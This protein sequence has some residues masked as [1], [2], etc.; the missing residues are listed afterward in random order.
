MGKFYIGSTD[1]VD[2]RVREHNEAELGAKTFTHKLGPWVLLWSERHVSRA[3][4][5]AR[6]KQ[7]KRMK[8][9]K[10]GRDMRGKADRGAN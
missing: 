7:I 2:R 4:A 10:C 8:S 9:A 1:D 5:M 6:E 3:A